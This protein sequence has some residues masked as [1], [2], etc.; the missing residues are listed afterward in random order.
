MSQWLMLGLATAVGLML[1]GAV[2]IYACCVL[3][4]RL[5]NYDER[6]YGI[7]RS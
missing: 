7:R 5:D 6:V 4:G 2:V 3:N 1:V